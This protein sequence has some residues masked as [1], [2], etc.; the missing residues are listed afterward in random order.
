MRI[1]L[2]DDHAIVRKG[3][4]QILAEEWPDARFGEAGSYQEGLLSAGGE[5][6]DVIITD[7]SLP[8]KSGIELTRQMIASGIPAPILILSIHP[9]EFYASKALRAGARGYLPKEAAPNDL[10]EAVK[11]VRSGRRFLTETMRRSLSTSIDPEKDQPA[12]EQLSEREFQVLVMLSTGKSL[13]QIA[14]HLN[15]SVNTI[16][17]YRSR[18]LEKLKV[19]S[20]AA[21]MHYAISHNLV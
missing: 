12:H 20:T 21:I 3:L 5:D 9:E 15:L 4:R 18:I 19:D 1:L 14:E 2:I 16:S 6:W 7:V 10:I 11:T 17:T 8:D 13:T